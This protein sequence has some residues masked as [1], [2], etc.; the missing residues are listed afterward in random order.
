MKTLL[1]TLGLLCIVPLFVACTQNQAPTPYKITGDFISMHPELSEEVA[2]GDETSTDEAETE[3]TEAE[4]PLEQEVDTSLDLSN[5]TLTISYETTDRQGNV[6]TISLVEQAFDGNFEFESETIEPTEVTISLQVSEDTDPMEINT[7]IGTGHDIHFTLIDHPSP[8]NPQFVLAGTTSYVMDPESKFVVSG[9]L[10]FLD[11][12]L[13]EDTTVLAYARV[14][15]EEGNSSWQEWGPVLVQDNSF[16]IEG[17][18]KEPLVATLNISGS[19]Y[20]GSTSMILEPHGDYTVAKLGNQTEELGT[21]SGSGYHAMLIESW[22][23]TDE[24]ID[25]VDA[26][27][28]EFEL[29]RNPPEPSESEEVEAQTPKDEDAGDVAV[30]EEVDDL[31]EDAADN[32]ESDA[33]A[34]ELVAAVEPAEGCEDAVSED[35]Q[36]PEP[37]SSSQNYVPKYYTLREQAREVRAKTLQTLFES[38]EDSTAQYLAMAL[39]PYTDRAKTLSGWQSLEVKFDE[40]FV[41]ARIKPEIDFLNWSVTAQ[42]NNAALIPGQR[43]PEFTLANAM[44][45]D[46][47]LYDLLG[48]KDMVLID[49]WASWCGPCIADFPELKKLHAAYQDEDFEIVGISIDSEKEDWIEGLEEH[50]L[51]W[52]NLGELKDWEGPVATSYGVMGIPMGY[53]VDSQG[54]IYDKHVRPAALKEFLVNRYGEDE[55]LVEPE[56]ETDDSQGVSG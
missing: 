39:G 25:L 16:H 37:F 36:Q 20:Y 48:E 56:T 9:D 31:E 19:N 55:S 43:V 22:Q 28:T 12:D 18:A 5:A 7:V 30:E 4:T 23:Q 15:D 27:T 46:L 35:S 26:W 13:T 44:D 41:A 52:I 3:E 14:Y 8:R 11:V 10:R 29:F 6:E 21:T 49:F 54:C 53:L 17:D 47:A 2:P 40:K 34:I 24:Y 33:D 51:P 50:K 32:E 45:E 42:A 1:K 38:S